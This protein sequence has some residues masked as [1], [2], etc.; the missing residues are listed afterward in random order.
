[1]TPGQY[2]GLGALLPELLR[3]GMDESWYRYLNGYLAS[4]RGAN[5]RNELLHGFVDEPSQTT[6]ALTMVG[7]LYLAIREPVPPS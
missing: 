2:P 6:A 1:M 3:A 7:A 5:V 4:P